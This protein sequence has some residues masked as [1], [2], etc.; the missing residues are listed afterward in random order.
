MF[1]QQSLWVS[2]L[3]ICLLAASCAAMLSTL[4]AQENAPDEELARQ[5]KIVERFV[6]VLEKNPRRGTALDRVYG[7]Y[8]ESGTLDQLVK[9]YQDRTKEPKDTT[10]WMI[11]GLIESQRGR[12]AA[13]VDAFTKAATVAPKDPLPSY[14]LG[15]SLVLV[16]QPEQ[17]V[18]AFEEAIS[19]KQVQNDLL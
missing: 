17:A 9:R 3:A 4:A 6:T 11:L 2:R 5:Q 19:R 7:F 13:A 8:V 16:G 12:D 14:Y 18:A 1:A 10:A 15:Q